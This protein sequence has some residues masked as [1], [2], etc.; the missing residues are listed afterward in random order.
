MRKKNV[1]FTLGA[2]V[3]ISS[4]S[5]ITDEESFSPSEESKLSLISEQ[6]MASNAGSGM[7]SGT[8]TF[9]GDEVI[10]HGATVRSFITL[11]NFAPTEFGYEMSN[12]L[13]SNLPTSGVTEVLITLPPLPSSGCTG[14]CPDQLSNLGFLFDH[15]TLHWYP[16]G[17]DPQG[18]FSFP[19]FDFH[20]YTIPLSE[21]LAINENDSSISIAPDPIY[22][23]D[24]YYGPIGPISEMGSHWV[25]LL[26]P[27]FNGGQFTKTFIYGTNNGNVIFE[28]MSITLAYLLSSSSLNDV[29]AIR[30]PY[31]Y[32]R[33][34]YYPL[35]YRIVKNSTTTRV[36]F[37][38]FVLFSTSGTSGI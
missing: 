30:Q 27:E 12:A 26:S 28:E 13:F 9:F 17:S 5:C 29:I 7:V 10:F 25:D 33:D 32:Q 21:R 31:T 8:G 4:Y 2:I 6:Q 37:S 3:L 34:G 15:I 19:K 14:N 11:D 22:M 16:N 38:D 23:A 18:I 20:C 36:Y 1:V 24:N 35:N